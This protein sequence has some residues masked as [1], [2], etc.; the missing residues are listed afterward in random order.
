MA[1][2]V[3][4]QR[5]AWL[6][7]W[8]WGEAMGALA[9]AVWA[10][11]FHVR[12]ARQARL[13]AALHKER[14]EHEALA[15]V[16]Q[17]AAVLAHKMRNP[18]ASLKGHVQLIAEAD[19][20][21]PQIEQRV[22]TAVSEVERLESLVGGLLNYARERKPKL[23]VS[24]L[25]RLVEQA[26]AFARA[27]P[28]H[29]AH[30]D[31]SVPSGLK[32]ETDSQLLV[33]ALQAVLEN[34]LEAAGES[35]RVRVSAESRPSSHGRAQV[36][37]EIEDDGPGF[38]EEEKERLLEPFVTSKPTGTGIGLAIAKRNIET[39]GGSLELGRSRLLGG[40]RV[41]VRLAAMGGSGHVG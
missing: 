27:R 40:A 23:T 9:V 6:S 26:V 5:A 1:I 12:Q 14:R 21:G 18:L 7:T 34:A 28:G 13:I 38:P 25:D 11:L 24:E 29:E 15:R 41:V 30:V 37:I 2:L 3:D 16:G 19:G 36:V 20:V 4:R 22:A 32:V 8:A 39:L 35:G 33:E 17:M 31:V 10:I